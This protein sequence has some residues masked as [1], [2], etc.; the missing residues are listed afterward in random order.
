MLD[1]D[2]LHDSFSAVK[3]FLQSGG[4]N[5]MHGLECECSVNVLSPR[6]F[7]NDIFEFEILESVPTYKLHSNTFKANGYHK[8][9]W[10]AYHLFE[11]NEVEKELT[12]SLNNRTFKLKHNK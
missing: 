8:P 1:F 12:V 9:V 6:S 11:W 5:S 7:H 2:N 4:Y 3:S 10:S